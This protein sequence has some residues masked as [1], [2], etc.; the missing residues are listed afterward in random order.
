MNIVGPADKAKKVGMPFQY[1]DIAPY[2]LTASA[3]DKHHG[4]RDAGV[5]V[6]HVIPAFRKL[7]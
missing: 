5:V 3:H 7:K 1:S 4:N 6:Q 2:H